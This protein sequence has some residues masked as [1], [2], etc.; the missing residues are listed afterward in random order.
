MSFLAKLIK[1]KENSEKYN[2]EAEEL[3]QAIFD[4]N[5]LYSQYDGEF[6]EELKQFIKNYETINKTTKT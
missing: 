3:K 4:I 6:L 5:S 1:D 2:K